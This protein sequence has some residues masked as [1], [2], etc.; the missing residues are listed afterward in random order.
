MTN[1]KPVSNKKI[2]HKDGMCSH[3]DTITKSQPVIMKSLHAPTGLSSHISHN[4]I[5]GSLNSN[6]NKMKIDKPPHF[7]N[8]TDSYS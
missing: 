1:Y 3:Q 6:T 4:L 7:I 8:S 2:S 5:Y